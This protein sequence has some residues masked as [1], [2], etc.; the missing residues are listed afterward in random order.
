VLVF[1][2]SGAL[3]LQRRSALK[4]HSPGLWS[5]TCCG[6]PRPGESV[7]DA[8]RRRLRDELG[9][10]GCEVARVDQ[11]V[12]RAALEGGLVEY[13]L[14]HVLVGSW[15]GRVEPD[16]EEVSETRWVDRDRLLAELVEAPGRYTAWIRNVIQR[17]FDGRQGVV[18][19][20]N[21]R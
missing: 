10:E 11:F 16:P 18:P 5:N 4:Y 19:A 13:E 9:I 20:L 15:N 12:Y 17:A 1:D 6:H 8:A 7:E 2:S 21:A 3:L 14:D